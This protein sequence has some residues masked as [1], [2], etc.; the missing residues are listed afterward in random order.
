MSQPAGPP[1]YDATYSQGVKTDPVESQPQPQALYVITSR[2]H[3]VEDDELIFT[4]KPAIV[5]CPTCKAIIK[6]RH[7]V[8]PAMR[9]HMCALILCCC[10][11]SLYSY[12]LK[13]NKASALLGSQK[14]EYC[15]LATCAQPGWVV[16]LNSQFNPKGKR[17]IKTHNNVF[18]SIAFI[19]LKV[20]SLKR[21]QYELIVTKVERK[22]T[23][24]THVIALLLCLFLCWPCVCVPYC[25]NS[26]Q[27]AD[28]Y[29][30]NCNSYLGTYQR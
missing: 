17:L 27:N 6:T 26:C 5:K 8:K 1:P 11:Y 15:S 18:L 24:K 22:A 9:T 3:L 23:T 4:E 29:C 21:L 20:Q 30:P 14:K 10:G 13:K 19:T 16:S 12:S 28:H 25:V 2:M 7:V